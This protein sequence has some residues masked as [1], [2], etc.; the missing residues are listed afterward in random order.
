MRR[1]RWPAP[2]TP[3]PLFS[4]PQAR[5]SHRRRVGSSHP[6]S[7]AAAGTVPFSGAEGATLSSPF[8]RGFMS[9]IRVI[10]NILLTPMDARSGYVVFP[11][12]AKA[13]LAH[14]LLLKQAAGHLLP[15]HLVLREGP[16]P[17]GR[18]SRTGSV[19]APLSVLRLP[20]SQPLLLLAS[21]VLCSPRSSHSSL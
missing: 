15:D 12:S 18:T 20:A 5:A 2:G 3:A 7:V 10:L 11:V 1:R 9:L 17:V 21:P 6:E 4:R 19:P 8:G 13:A 14:R 16:S